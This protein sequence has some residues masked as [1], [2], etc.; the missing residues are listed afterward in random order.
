MVS[1][2][3]AEVKIN[4]QIFKKVGKLEEVVA[5]ITAVSKN[6]WDAHL[7]GLYTELAH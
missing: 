7:Y 2:I 4:Q 1:V 6:K 3:I 5:E